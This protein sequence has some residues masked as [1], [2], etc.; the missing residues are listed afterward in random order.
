VCLGGKQLGHSDS[1][2]LCAAFFFLQEGRLGIE[3]TA[4][5][6]SQCLRRAWDW[7]ADAAAEAA[8]AASAAAATLV[9]TAAAGTTDAADDALRALTA[10]GVLV[11]FVALLPGFRRSLLAARNVEAGAGAGRGSPQGAAGSSVP[12]ITGAQGPMAAGTAGGE[13]RAHHLQQEQQPEQQQEQQQEQRGGRPFV[14]GDWHCVV[15]DRAG[16]VARM[17]VAAAGSGRGAAVMGEVVGRLLTHRVR[18]V[19]LSYKEKG[20]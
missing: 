10:L 15:H 5:H 19:L 20:L 2:L 3:A 6:A 7:W 13:A 9:Q 18:G 8:A 17:D 1:R 12:A 16:G 11:L 14:A 4:M